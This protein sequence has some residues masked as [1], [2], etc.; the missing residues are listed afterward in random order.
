MQSIAAGPLSSTPGI[1]VKDPAFSYY[2]AGGALG[3]SF[4]QIGRC[5]EQGK[6]TV[7]LEND[8]VM[9]I[10]PCGSGLR[11]RLRSKKSAQRASVEPDIPADIQGLFQRTAKGASGKG[12]CHK[13]S[14]SDKN[15]FDTFDMF[16]V[17][18]QSEGSGREPEKGKFPKV[19]RRGCK[20]WFGLRE[21][22]SPKSLLHHPK[23]VLHRCNPI[24]HWCNPIFAPWAQKTFCT[25]S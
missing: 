20:R 7:C 13:T 1:A 14:K 3:L 11:Q 4:V 2:F 25:L 18:L 16:R 21:Q 5:Q 9:A 10:K 15:M 8:S 17:G 22:K 23:P 12:P 6:C 24:L 19:V